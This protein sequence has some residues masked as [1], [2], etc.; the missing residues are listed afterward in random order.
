MNDFF[1]Q[2]GDKLAYMLRTGKLKT[3]LRFANGGAVGATLVGVDDQGNSVGNIVN[4]LWGNDSGSSD[5]TLGGIGDALQKAGSGLGTGSKGKNADSPLGGGFYNSAPYIAQH[6]TQ[7]GK[8]F[9]GQDAPRNMEVEKPQ[10]QSRPTP[11][12]KP[13][14]FYARWYEGMRRLAEA[15]EI[16][17]RGQPT[18]RSR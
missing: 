12:E 5:S 1:D 18:V 3:P 4:K 16:T 2:Q 8:F 9:T 17:N 6:Y 15:E 11:S 13:T 7:L 14:D 10:H